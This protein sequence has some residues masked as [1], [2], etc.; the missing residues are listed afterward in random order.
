MSDPLAPLG[1]PLGG[2]SVHVAD[3][4]SPAELLLLG[5]PT[6]FEDGQYVIL[7]N[8]LFMNRITYKLLK[9]SCK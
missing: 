3:D 6:V 5:L 9:E 7:G 1:P 4:Y 8:E 2:F